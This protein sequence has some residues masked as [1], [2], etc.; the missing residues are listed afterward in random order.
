MPQSH[1]LNAIFKGTSLRAL[2]VITVSDYRL[3]KTEVA[4]Y[5]PL[6]INSVIKM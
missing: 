6:I 1:S 5:K 3:V 4:Y 2:L